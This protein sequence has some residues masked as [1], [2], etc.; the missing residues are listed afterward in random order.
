MPRHGHS[1]SGRAVHV[2]V[3][4][5]VVAGRG[6]CS[7]CWTV[8]R[9]TTYR[10]GRWVGPQR[11]WL[12][13][14]LRNVLTAA[15][16]RWTVV[17]RGRGARNTTKGRRGKKVGDVVVVVVSERASP[18]R[19]VGVTGVRGCAG[20][21][22]A[23]AHQICAET[24]TLRPDAHHAG[25]W[26]DLLPERLERHQDQQVP[27]ARVRDSLRGQ[28]RARWQRRKTAQRE[29]RCASKRCAFA[30]GC[31][32]C[33]GCDAI[34]REH[35]CIRGGVRMPQGDRRVVVGN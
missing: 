34:T 25:G 23:S 31:D 4:T 6:A 32:G 16:C 24:A 19:R 21:P 2:H 8:G 17:R 10:R 14:R 12:P 15:A 13:V 26:A 1:S 3:R 30:G 18:W 27:E 35:V 33:D 7:L 5:P 11:M 29:G 9:S 28:R 22:A 20:L